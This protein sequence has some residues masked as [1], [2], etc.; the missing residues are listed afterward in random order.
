MFRGLQ[1]M[2][3]MMHWL[4]AAAVDTSTGQTNWFYY[5]IK[6]TC[7]PRIQSLKFT[8]PRSSWVLNLSMVLRLITSRFLHHFVM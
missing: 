3:M 4:L 8:M 5:L 6:L 7:F 2:M 1:L